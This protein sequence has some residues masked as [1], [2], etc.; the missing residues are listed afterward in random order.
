[1][2]VEIQSCAEL[3]IKQIQCITSALGTGYEGQES[4]AV[5]LCLALGN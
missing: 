4:A 3:T 2:L 5:P 1:M